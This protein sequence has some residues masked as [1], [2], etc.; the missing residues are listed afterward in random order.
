M[1]D[2]CNSNCYSPTSTWCNHAWPDN[3]LHVPNKAKENEQNKLQKEEMHHSSSSLSF[4]TGVCVHIPSAS[5]PQQSRRRRG[6]A[7]PGEGSSAVLGTR[8]CREGTEHIP[9]SQVSPWPWK[10][11]PLQPLSH[12]TRVPCILRHKYFALSTQ[13]TS[14]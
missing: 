8:H 5:K 2:V 14:H 6:A 12:G 13:S 10:A 4:L 11:P 7:A 1:L 9:T 3:V